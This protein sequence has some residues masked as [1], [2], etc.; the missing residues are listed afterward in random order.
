M[1][2]FMTLTHSW[3]GARADPHD[4]LANAPAERKRGRTEFSERAG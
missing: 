2:S 3:A 1:D 4:I